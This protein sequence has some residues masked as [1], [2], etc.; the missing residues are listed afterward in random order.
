MNFDD[1]TPA[2][3]VVANQPRVGAS[4]LGPL[5]RTCSAFS[6]RELLVAGPEPRRTGTH[7]VHGAN[8][9]RDTQ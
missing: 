1:H 3:W 4:N 2:C 5:L 7:G 6:V 9:A 8:V